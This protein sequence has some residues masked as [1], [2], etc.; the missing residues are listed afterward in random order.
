M[1]P[2]KIIII[3]WLVLWI[4]FLARDLFVHGYLRDYSELLNRDA[5]GKRAYTYG[6][7]LYKFLKFAKS[8]IP[9]NNS[10]KLIGLENLSLAHRRAIYYLYPLIEK[11][12]PDYVLNVKQ[13]TLKKL[14]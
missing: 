13:A 3:I 4:N 12:K 5:E 14:K 9:L 2:L 8:A 7:D 11:D 10:Y 1:K 6:D